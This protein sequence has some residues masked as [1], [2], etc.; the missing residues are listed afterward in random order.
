MN[1]GTFDTGPYGIGQ[2]PG[3][4]WFGQE[5]GPLVRPY[6]MTGGRTTAGPQGAHLDMIAL[7]SA[8]AA[9]SDGAD[10]AILAPEHR[11]ILEL[12]RTGTQTVAELAADT[13]LPVGVIRVL[14]GGLLERGRIE[15]SGPVPPTQL[16]DEQTLRD[17]ID[18]LRAL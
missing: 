8:V 11:S 13:D 16:P 1:D 17:V 7:V 15:V 6:A 3:G 14:L 2:E 9:A 10:G 12:C 5:A 4:Q 18:G